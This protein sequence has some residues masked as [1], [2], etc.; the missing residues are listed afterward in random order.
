MRGNIKSLGLLPLHAAWTEDKNTPTGKRYAL[1]LSGGML[2]TNQ[3]H[4]GVRCITLIYAF[5][6]TSLE[7]V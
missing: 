5:I 2:R 3:R 7:M 1:A 4:I 6:L